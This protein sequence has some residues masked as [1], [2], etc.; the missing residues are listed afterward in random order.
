[1]RI[2][3]YTDHLSLPLLPGHRFPISKYRLTRELLA[4]DGLYEFIPA[5]AEVFRMG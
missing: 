1:V 5:Q 3:Y 4:G 2:L